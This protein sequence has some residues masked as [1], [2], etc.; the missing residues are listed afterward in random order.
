M[1]IMNYI[2]RLYPDALQQAQLLEWLE[3]Y[4]G[5]YNYAL[6]ELKDWIDSRKCLAEAAEA[7]HS[8]EGE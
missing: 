1:L 6:R 8:A 4:R 7:P 3:T 5:V 2:Y